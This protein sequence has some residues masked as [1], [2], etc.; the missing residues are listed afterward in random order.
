MRLE[1]LY[2]VPG[3]V[4]R[5]RDSPTLP[6]A[7]QEST[8]AAEEHRLVRLEARRVRQ[9]LAHGDGGD[10][11]VG[12]RGADDVGEALADRLVEPELAGLDELQ[13]DDRRDHLADAGDAEAVARLDRLGRRGGRRVVVVVVDGSGRGRRRD[14][15]RGRHGR[16]RDAEAEVGGVHD[17]AVDG[18][19]DPDGVV[20]AADQA[21]R[22]GLVERRPSLGR[23][24][25]ARC[26][27]RGG[28][29]RSAVDSVGD[30]PSGP[31]TLS[32]G[33]GSCGPSAS[34]ASA[35]GGAT[36]GRGSNGDAIA[37]GAVLGRA[38]RER[39]HRQRERGP[40]AGSLS[41][42]HDAGTIPADQVIVA[43]LTRVS[44]RAGAAP[45]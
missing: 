6:A 38:G 2:S 34:S 24:R 11:R 18:D 20:A 9:Q 16:R 45:A 28:R 1:Y 12:D 33:D 41:P 13:H 42:H 10:L 23:G 44:R 32:S 7:G 29:G 19:G 39:H 17:L 21:R 40:S 4:R 27:G 35:S 37:R 31:P 22:E 43:D 15:R 5:P 3:G 36:V 8:W 14:R 30:R 25:R 26:R